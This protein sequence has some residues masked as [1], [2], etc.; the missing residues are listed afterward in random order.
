M[1]DLKVRCKGCRKKISPQSNGIYHFC[2]TD[3]KIAW[4]NS[5]EGQKKMK[6]TSKVLEKESKVVMKESAKSLSDYATEL[7][8][9]V[10]HIV[11][12]IDSKQLCISSQKPPKQ[13]HGGHYFSTSMAGFLRFNLFNIYAQ[14]AHSNT[15]KSGDLD[16]Y[17]L[18]LIS[19]FGQEHFDF[20]QSLRLKYQHLKF[21]KDLLKEKIVIAREIVRELKKADLT[22]STQERLELREMYNNQLGIY[23]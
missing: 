6:I 4:L 7:Q 21:T 1:N 8:K 9:E 16:N 13:V 3:C 2:G 20:V 5:P 19:T 12:L 22:Y 14:S 23:L 11:R 17:R 15:Y 10:N 18:G